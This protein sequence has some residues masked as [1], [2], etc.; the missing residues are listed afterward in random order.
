[1]VNLSV[2]DYA[3]AEIKSLKADNNIDWG[4]VLGFSG[5][6]LLGFRGAG[7]VLLKPLENGGLA[8]QRETS[9]H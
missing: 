8:E 9:K 5:E 3:D 4:F 6:V 7:W 1:M 2:V